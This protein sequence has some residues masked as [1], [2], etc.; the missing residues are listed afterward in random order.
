MES[1]W[2]G[3]GGGGGRGKRKHDKKFLQGGGEKKLRGNEEKAGPGPVL[4][5]SANTRTP[6]REKLC[7][8]SLHF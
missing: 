1:E 8:V 5:K 4:K 3:G 6:Q 2:G 7:P